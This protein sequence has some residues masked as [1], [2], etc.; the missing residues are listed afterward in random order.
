MEF[1]NKFHEQVKLKIEKKNE[2]YAKHANKGMKIVVFEPSDWVWIHLWKERFPTQ[3][4]SKIL[5][6]GDGLFKVLERTNDNGYKIDLTVKY[7]VHLT[8]NVAD[9]SPFNL[10][11]EDFNLRSISL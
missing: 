8:F 2:G 4:N 1:V 11:E 9:L 7:G 3:R 6:R 5:P 10:G